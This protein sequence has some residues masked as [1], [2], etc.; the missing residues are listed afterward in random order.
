M[1]LSIYLPNNLAY[2]AR[3]RLQQRTVTCR[4]LFKRPLEAVFIQQF[5]ALSPLTH[6]RRASCNCPW[7]L[8]SQAFRQLR[9]SREIHT[10]KLPAR[11]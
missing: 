9:H 6:S 11:Y 3:N 2:D 5:F 1:K 4:S 7:D 10:D 8:L